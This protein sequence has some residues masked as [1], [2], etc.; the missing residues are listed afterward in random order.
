MPPLSELPTDLSLTK[1]LG[2]LEQLN[3]FLS[4]KG[5]KGSHTKMV[6]RPNG[7]SFTILYSGKKMRQDVLYSVLKDI[8]ECTRVTWEDIR[9]M[10]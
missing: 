5:G 9:D 1:F 2:A 6:Y 10:M 4:K 7:K 8:K 3:F